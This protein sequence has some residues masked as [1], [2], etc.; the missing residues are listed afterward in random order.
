MENNFNDCEKEFLE[1]LKIIDSYIPAGYALEIDRWWSCDDD[2]VPGWYVMKYS[3]IDKCAY[4]LNEYYFYTEPIITEAEAIEKEI[5]VE[6]CLDYY[7][8]YYVG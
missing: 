6:K 2:L 7:G 4:P 8:C 1:D 5:D 3:E